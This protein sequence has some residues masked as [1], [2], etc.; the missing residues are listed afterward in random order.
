MMFQ[1]TRLFLLVFEMAKLFSFAQVPLQHPDRTEK[2]LISILINKVKK[3]GDCVAGFWALDTKS[4]TKLKVKDL[5]PFKCLTR[6]MKPNNSLTFLAE[7]RAKKKQ[8]F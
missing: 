4:G 7:A 6:Y 8:V 3:R 1:D 5:Q 2:H